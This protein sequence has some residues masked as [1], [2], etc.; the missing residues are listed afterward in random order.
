M[1]QWESYSHSVAGRRERNEDEVLLLPLGSEGYFMAV[2]DGMGGIKG[3]EIASAIV[4]TFAREFLTRRFKKPVRPEQLKKIVRELYAGADAAVKR[5]QTAHP[6]LAGM[7]TTL[8][9]VLVQG[10]KYVVANIGDSRVYR[11]TPE[12]FEQL[13][14]DHTYVQDMMT[15]SGVKPDARLVENFGHVVTRSIQGAKDKPDI[16][17]REDRTFTLAEGEGFLLCSDGLISDKSADQQVQLEVL[18]RTTQGLQEAS[19]NMVNSALEAGSTDNISVVLAT[20][21]A[22]RRSQSH[23]EVAPDPQTTVTLKA[24]APVR[25]PMSF[26]R[27]PRIIALVALA[28]LAL[29]LGVIVWASDGSEESP[30]EPTIEKQTHGRVKPSHG[31]TEEANSRLDSNSRNNR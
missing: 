25:K 12:E 9:C 11:C 13:T 10:T 6:H 28:I 3:G 7:G 16:F 8:A 21:G 5:E 15:R 18:F 17:P 20:F 2:A 19:E 14:V 23:P 31:K 1:S 26:A 27:S 22:F 4:L 29:V 30:G 24:V